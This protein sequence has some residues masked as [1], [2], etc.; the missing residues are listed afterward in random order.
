M[1]MKIGVKECAGLFKTLV[2]ASEP[3]WATRKRHVTIPWVYIKKHCIALSDC[4]R[5]LHRDVSGL[6]PILLHPTY[7]KA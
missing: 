3:I 2:G 4:A 5:A 6:N 7:N 1:F